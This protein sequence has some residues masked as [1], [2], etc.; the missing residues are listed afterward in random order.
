MYS[1][2]LI[3]HGE[4]EGNLSGVIHS[5]FNSPIFHLGYIDYAQFS[6]NPAPHQGARMGF[7]PQTR[8]TQP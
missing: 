2:I 8:L 5:F 4:S 3:I 6:Y 7:I 1:I